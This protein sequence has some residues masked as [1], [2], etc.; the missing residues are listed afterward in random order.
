[1]RTS[2][3][4][5]VVK[6]TIS[7]L[8]LLRGVFLRAKNDTYHRSELKLSGNHLRMGSDFLLLAKIEDLWNIHLEFRACPVDPFLLRGSGSERGAKIS[9][10]LTE[11]NKRA[12]FRCSKC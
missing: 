11:G 6:N 4:R 5:N 8:Y 7:T 9:L 2:D 10:K 12:N 3:E 1:M